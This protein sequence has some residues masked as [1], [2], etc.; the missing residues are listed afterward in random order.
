MFPGRNDGVRDAAAR[1]DAFNAGKRCDRSEK[2]PQVRVS[3]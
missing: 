2:S 3:V 1:R